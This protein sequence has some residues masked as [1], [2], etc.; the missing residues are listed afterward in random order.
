MEVEDGVMRY[1][2]GLRL[3]RGRCLT[4]DGGARR[5]VDACGARWDGGCLC[6]LG[7]VVGSVA[8]IGARAIPQPRPTSL[9]PSALVNE[10]ELG[11]KKS[12]T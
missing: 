5:R 9:R 4:T 1:G 12:G 2:M 3:E 11:I 6:A 8:A 7:L 10:L